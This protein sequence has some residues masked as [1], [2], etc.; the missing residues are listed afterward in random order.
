MLNEPKHI[1]L[2]GIGGTGLSAIAKVLLEQGH[3]VSGSDM[4][5]SPLADAIEK[6]GA[7]VSIGHDASN[8]QGAELVIQSS[9]IPSTNPELIAAQQAGIPVFKRSAFLKEWLVGK[10][11]LA[12]AGTHGKTT[13]TS[14]LAWVLDSLGHSP[15]FIIGSVAKNLGT[16]ARAGNDQ[17]FVIEADEYDYMFHGLHPKLAIITNLQHDHPDCFPTM[18][19]YRKAFQDFAENIAPHGH[20]IVCADDAEASQLIDKARPDIQVHTYGF[21]EKADYRLSSLPRS[22]TY[23]FSIVIN[24]TSSAIL[25]L[26]VAGTH[27]ALNAAG[28]IAAA[29]QLGCDIQ[30]TITALAEFSGSE[31]RFDILGTWQGITLIDDYAHHPTEI[32]ATLQAS[33]QRF[34]QS[35]IWVV[36]QPHTYS[37]TITLLAQFSTC[38]TDADQVLVT[39]V[40]AARENNDAFSG[41]HLVNQIQHDHVHFTPQLD[42]A[43]EYLSTAVTHGDVV[44]VCSAGSAIAI[45]QQLSKKIQAAM[46]TDAA[47]HPAT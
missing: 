14:M 17:Y 25:H 34:P 7:T 22:N 36:W 31:R 3:I 23:D 12:V 28:V 24:G 38:F 5:R 42:D 8:V 29:D 21:S 32:K 1:H 26:Q 4:Q 40:Y 15:S 11:C 2:I 20:L 16:N 41:Q 47:A 9:A 18:E 10:E 39:D 30:K 37:R 19:I 45:N 43:V 13:T 33:R 46:E 35:R 27:N 6:A 44:I